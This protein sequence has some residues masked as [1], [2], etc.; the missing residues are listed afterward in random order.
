M[1][2]FGGFRQVKDRQLWRDQV[3]LVGT[4]QLGSGSRGKLRPVEARF[5]KV[6]YFVVWKGSRGSLGEAV[7]GKFWQGLFRQG[8]CGKLRLFG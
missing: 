1:I 4:G 2:C 5:C 3:V 8:S 6:W 7:F